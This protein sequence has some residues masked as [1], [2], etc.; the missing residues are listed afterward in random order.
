MLRRSFFVTRPYYHAHRTPASLSRAMRATKS[1]F[2]RGRVVSCP[3][4]GHPI[5][6][7]NRHRATRGV[8][9]R[10]CKVPVCERRLDA[11]RPQQGLY[12][13][14]V[15]ESSSPA[16]VQTLERAH[17]PAGQF[18]LRDPSRA[19]GIGFEAAAP[20]SSVRAI[21]VHMRCIVYLRAS[22]PLIRARAWRRRRRAPPPDLLAVHSVKMFAVPIFG[23]AALAAGQ[24]QEF[25]VRRPLTVGGRRGTT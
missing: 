14:L 2:L 23:K 12:A 21:T 3:F 16:A 24:P 13:K 8:R 1:A 15:S 9:S 4:A 11:H 7:G 10:D 20:Q 17:A 18:R 5:D 22:R 19:R 6:I 25:L